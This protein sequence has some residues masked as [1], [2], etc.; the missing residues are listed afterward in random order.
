MAKLL[1]RNTNLPLQVDGKLLARNIENIPG[2]DMRISSHGWGMTL[3]IDTD[4]TGNSFKI[5][6][7]S[8][9][10]ETTL[11][12]ING[13]NNVGIGT[14]SPSEKLEV[15]GRIKA[16]NL[17]YVGGVNGP[18]GA[19][20]VLH[21]SYGGGGG[22]S[23]GYGSGMSATPVNTTD[24]TSTTSAA[25]V[26][27]P[28]GDTSYNVPNA[29]TYADIY[30]FGN[31]FMLIGS[32]NVYNG[33]YLKPLFFAGER[34]IELKFPL[35]PIL[36]LYGLSNPSSLRFNVIANTDFLNGSEIFTDWD[37]TSYYVDTV[38]VVMK[39]Y[40]LWNS[41]Y[42]AYML[43]VILRRLRFTSSDGYL[44]PVIQVI[45]HKV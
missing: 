10:N 24:P 21:N 7:G 45:G 14:S 29:F 44:R 33:S 4:S 30:A 40:T 31:A 13:S 12:V 17:G 8:G 5:T 39:H 38:Y 1:K 2:D 9:S 23:A 6:R 3:N 16:T 35:T 22:N 11:L 18:T 37:A 28:A 26:S 43:H 27:V 41:S 15:N 25:Q 20:V 36:N 42:N 34:F 32:P 19:S